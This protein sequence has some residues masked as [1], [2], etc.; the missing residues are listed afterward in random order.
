MKYP[1]YLDYSKESTDNCET[2]L[3]TIW[4]VLRDFHDDLVLVGGL[5]PRY[6]CRPSSQE[7]H[8]VTMD[9]DLGIARAC[10]IRVIFPK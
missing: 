1:Y 2:A 6:F 4:A 9:V 5:A 8:P 7:I 3:L 10:P